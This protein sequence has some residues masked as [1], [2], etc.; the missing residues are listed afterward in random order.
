MP[1]KKEK[2]SSKEKGNLR[3][4]VEESMTQDLN[5]QCQPLNELL[6]CLEGE[7]INPSLSN[8]MEQEELAQVVVVRA[9]PLNIP[10]RAS[11]GLYKNSGS[12]EMRLM[13]SKYTRSK[14]SFTR[15]CSTVY[16]PSSHT[17]EE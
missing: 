7:D 16:H 6:K 3:A 17:S 9:T 11:C 13:A 1:C 8:F 10:K 12:Y 4:P 5:E 2:H 15:K 14:Y